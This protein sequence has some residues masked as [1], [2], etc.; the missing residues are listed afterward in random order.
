LID[1]YAV[2]TEPVSVLDKDEIKEIKIYDLK[3]TRN[4]KAVD[5]EYI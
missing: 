1:K 3:Q 2:E 4:P 5:V